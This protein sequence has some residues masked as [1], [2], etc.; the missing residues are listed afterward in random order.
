MRLIVLTSVGAAFAL[1]PAAPAAARPGDLPIA[2]D[3]RGSSLIGG[4]RPRVNASRAAAVREFGADYRQGAECQFAWPRIGLTVK[5]AN[6]GV[7]D[8]CGFAQVAYVAGTNSQ[9]W[10]TSRG[11][12]VGD[13]FARLRSLY[14]Q[15]TRRG[16]VWRLVRGYFPGIGAFS[17]VSA[18]TSVGRVSQL[19]IWIGGAGE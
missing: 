4:L 10:R 12:R 6:F 19:R 8:P 9:R 1:L 2:G 17:V 18:R 13:S 7:G 5:M 11:L 16:T 3:S 15:A 14:P